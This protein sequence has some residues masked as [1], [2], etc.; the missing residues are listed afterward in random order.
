[1]TLP[2]RFHSGNLSPFGG[3]PAPAPEF[4]HGGTDLNEMVRK[5]QR[6]L[7]LIVGSL[8]VCTLAALFVVTQLQPRYSAF[9]QVQVGVPEPKV[10]S[11]TEAV[12][13]GQQPDAEVVRNES[14]VMA[15]PA[16]AKSVIATLGLDRDPEFNPALRNPPLW[17]RIGYF[18]EDLFSSTDDTGTRPTQDAA[19]RAKRRED[20]VI[21]TVLSKLD[22]E[23]V[24]RSYMLSIQA[25]FVD[26]VTA[27]K[28]ANGFANAYVEQQ[29]D[30]KWQATHDAEIY[31]K[32]R[33]ADMQ[34]QV[35]KSDQAVEDY[36]RR[37]GLLKG[38]TSSVTEQQLTELNTQ[39][40][41]AQA[42]KAEA[43]SKLGEALSLA[44]RSDAS[45]TIPAVLQSPTI[46]A[47]KQ[48]QI[49]VQRKIAELSS[50]YGEMHPK[51]Q[52]ARAEEAEL[53]KKIGLE[54]KRVIAGLRNESK[55]A[56]AR[57]E[58]LRDN[59]ARLKTEAGN[60]NEK[61]IEL[62]ALD[63]EA[64]ANRSML[65]AMLA[66]YKETI[67]QQDLVRADA[68]II[69]PASVPDS[70]SFPPR[71]LLIAVAAIGG[72]GIGVL[73]AFL[74]ENFDKTFRRPNEVEELTGLPTLAMVPTLTRRARP[75]HHVLDK[76]V[77]PFSD[78]LRR[79]YISMRCDNPSEPSRLI[80][81]ASAVPKEGK[82]VL[83]ASLS[84]L[85]ASSGR[86]VLLIDC[87]WRRPSQHRLFGARNRTG[88]AQVLAGEVAIENALHRDRESGAH[89]LFGGAS[90]P[91]HLHL[92]NSEA[93][94]QLLVD[95]ANGYD[96]VILDTPPV[97]VGAEVLHLSRLVDKTVFLARWGRTQREVALHALKQL[98][99][100]QG[101]VAGVVLSHVN[102][103]RYRYYSYAQL[104]YGYSKSAF[105]SSK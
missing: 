3:L 87:D 39:L 53:R 14:Y 45:E 37:T 85:L 1:M 86:R 40:I 33:I 55:S 91:G 71:V 101:H 20:R 42:A 96:A 93:M 38:A 46:Q 63:R 67:A 10:L 66:R 29:R 4:G 32:N 19:D 41:L 76:P 21:N 98:V 48:Q 28:L 81:V 43:D 44:K 54:V 92:L 7:K 57:Y 27:A 90:R 11:K 79:L 82:S 104:D 77:S 58:T 31:L 97:L 68:Q 59:F 61:S 34:R 95:L 9:A 49:E 88:L 13:A 26:P 47:M 72:L 62:Q 60:A 84:R 24:A 105:A 99:D 16:V 64:S 75:A 22:V 83:C 36:R 94:R 103:D 23:P 78:A 69:A 73:L 5:L 50:T 70:P 25:D 74:V 102:T 17:Q 65:E 18:F 6:H 8:V 56:D 2:S 52:N 15:S 89:V 100:A 80:M 35:A 30:R 12:M 51:M